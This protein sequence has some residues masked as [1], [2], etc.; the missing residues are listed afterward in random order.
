MMASLMVQEI[1][2]GVQ[3][4]IKVL[5]RSSKN[6]LCGLQGEAL[7]IKL[8]APPVDGAANEACLRFLA[9]QLGVPMGR[10]RIIS[11]QTNQHKLIRV[12]GLNRE[13]V[14]TKLDCSS[15]I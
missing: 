15:D 11:G 9:E 8:T 12:E 4:K 14:L 13:Q 3:F 6:Q 1:E 10:L 5:P 7:K 2:G